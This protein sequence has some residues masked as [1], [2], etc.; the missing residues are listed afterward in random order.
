METALDKLIVILEKKTTN[1][2]CKIKNIYFKNKF[3]KL[4]NI[5]RKI[6][7]LP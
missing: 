6:V 4:K 2:F 7:L 3:L 1:T 5:N